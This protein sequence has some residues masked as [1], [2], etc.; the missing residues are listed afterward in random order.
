MCGIA[1]YWNFGSG[2]PA[3]RDTLHAC[4][5]TLA[6]RGPDEDGF[7]IDGTL[8][9]GMRR[10]QVVDPSGGHQPMAGEDGS[11]RVVFNGEI[12]NHVELRQRL[13]AAGHRFRTRSDT[14][15]IVHAWEE[16]GPSCVE[17]FNG[18]F[19]LA[20]WDGRQQQ[21]FLA[22]DRLGIK[23]L[24]VWDGAAGMVFGSEL[25]AILAI[26]WVP[27]EWDLG[28]V[29]DFMTC[30]YVPAPRSIVAGVGK[31]EAGTWRLYDAGRPHA[32]RSH[33][34]WLPGSNGAAAPASPA[35][36]A[37]ELREALATSVRRRLMADVPLGAFLS[38]GID[39]SIIVGLMSVQTPGR[40]RTFSLG[41]EDR[42]YDEL[43]HARAVSSHFGTTHREARVTPDIVGLSNRLAGF[44]DEP[45]GDVSAFPTYLISA[46]ARNDVTVALSGDGGDELFAGYDHYRA[47]RWA[48][49][50][51]WATRGGGWDLVDRLL[52]AVPPRPTKKGA[53]NKA[54]RFAEGIRRPAD[55]EHARWLVFWDL[56]ERRAL[57]TGDALQGVRGRDPFQHHRRLIAEGTAQG[58]T[59]LQR[60]LYVDVR[61]YLADD[62]LAKV[63]RASMAVSLEVRVPFL[64]HE[65]VELA[66][67]L[68]D[69][70]KLRGG[71]RGGTGKWILKQA[72][73]PMLPP[74]TVRR[75]KEGFS[76]PMKNWLR[77]PLQPLM[78]ELLSASRLRDRGWFRP[79]TVERLVDEHVRGRRNHAH[80]LWCLMAL[81]LSLDGL[82]HAR[83]AATAPPGENLPRSGTGVASGPAYGGR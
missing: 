46:L 39:S 78:R 56:V 28:A 79:R 69:R 48:H 82:R 26:P 8:G 62:I 20:V 36:A 18:M 25:K 83:Q 81:E 72:F 50:V 24:Y 29:D 5:R 77:G 63:D 34:Y 4:T 55:L 73:A 49:R 12:Y 17:R 54:K 13:E 15:A 9:L 52:D 7:F 3:D 31:L 74:A 30:E 35:A 2:R 53:L 43:E 67:R 19:A 57:Y 33:R 38:G 47:D 1:G 70:W 22:R 44:Y 37:D 10:L 32:P 66:M 6:H 61:G 60:Q 41:F 71:L 59:G 58:F 80:R 42:S 51:R 45:F 27:M 76:M 40:V 11:V 64:D 16:W 14:E 68:P 75:G 23:P 65:V 21:L